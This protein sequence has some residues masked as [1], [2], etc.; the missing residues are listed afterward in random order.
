[1]SNF[2]FIRRSGCDKWRNVDSEPKEIDT[3]AV[4]LFVCVSVDLP[5]QV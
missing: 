1:M 4:I 5:I 2:L 3:I